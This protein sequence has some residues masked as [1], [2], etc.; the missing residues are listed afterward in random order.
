MAILVLLSLI[1][2]IAT[3]CYAQ[4]EYV[5]TDKWATF[6]NGGYTVRNDVW[7][8]GAGTQELHATTY[9]NW[10][11]HANHPNTGG[12]KAYAQV[13]KAVNKI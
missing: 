5:S 7:G 11:V 3:S 1:V 10:Y 8:S 6:E 2:I 13:A 12:V 4:T 9:K